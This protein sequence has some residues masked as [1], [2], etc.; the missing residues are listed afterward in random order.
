MQFEAPIACSVPSR[1]IPFGFLFHSSFSRVQARVK[2][3][4]HREHTES[5]SSPTILSKVEYFRSSR[6]SAEINKSFPSASPFKIVYLYLGEL[7]K[8]ISF[9]SLPLPRERVSPLW[10]TTS[11]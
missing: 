2:E 9:L 8:Y 7:Y 6:T 5:V 4:D 3:Q 10:F 11:Y 1:S